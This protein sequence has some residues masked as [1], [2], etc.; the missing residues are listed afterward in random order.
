LTGINESVAKETLKKF[1]SI[2]TLTAA[3]VVKAS[4]INGDAIEFPHRFLHS[5]FD[6]LKYNAV[7]YLSYFHSLRN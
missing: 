5:N 6:F 1:D 7:K 2:A 4:A 3:R